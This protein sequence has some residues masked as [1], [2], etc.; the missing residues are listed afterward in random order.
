MCEWGKCA[1]SPRQLPRGESLHGALWK[2]GTPE[3]EQ[4]A[5]NRCE[6]PKG[7]HTEPWWF[8]SVA[9]KK[10][11]CNKHWL[12]GQ[13][14][15]SGRWCS[16]RS[17]KGNISQVEDQKVPGEADIGRWLP[18][19]GRWEARGVKAGPGHRLP[20]RWA[21]QPRPRNLLGACLHLCC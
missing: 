4:R 21:S 9:I 11:V 8:C 13:M 12:R 10:P 18:G 3:L 14:N 15:D 5:K 19:L 17:G 7:T 1:I 2:R 20:C 16:G 6:G